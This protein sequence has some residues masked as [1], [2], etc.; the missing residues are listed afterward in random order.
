MPNSAVAAWRS[1]PIEDWK[2]EVQ[3]LWPETSFLTAQ[4]TRHEDLTWASYADVALD[5]LYAGRIAFIGDAAHSISPRLGQGA[6]LGLVDALVLA[7]AL[8]TAQSVMSALL[9][10]DAKRRSQVR[11]YHAASRWLSALF[12][13][14]S[15]IAPFLRDL[16]FA[17][18][19]RI[20][21]MRRQ[22]L[23]S[24]AGVKTGLFGRLEVAE[25]TRV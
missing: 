7:N 5:R 10:Y 22:M 21:Y 3:S 4:I 20:P 6:N 24:L 25:L 16:A 11:F 2:R 12:Q 9:T 17:P 13:S 19:S 1:A 8:G 15:V 14:D 23:D 18:V